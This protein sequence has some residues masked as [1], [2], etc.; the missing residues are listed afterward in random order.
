[1]EK[2]SRVKILYKK[3]DLRMQLHTEERV[4]VYFG[5]SG[6]FMMTLALPD[7]FTRLVS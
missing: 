4:S 6:F 2:G 3:N 5:A 7:R 1:M